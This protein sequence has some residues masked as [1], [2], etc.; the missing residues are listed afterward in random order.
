LRLGLKK[1]DLSDVFGILA[2]VILIVKV[3]FSR[4][5]RV[6]S[7]DSA[8][9]LLLLFFEVSEDSEAPETTAESKGNVLV[10]SIRAQVG[11]TSM[12]LRM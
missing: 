3:T 12:L 11:S 6:K 10:I 9:G 1:V 4:S 2:E 5:A 7:Y 8:E